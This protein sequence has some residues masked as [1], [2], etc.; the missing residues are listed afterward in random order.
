MPAKLRITAGSAKPYELEIGDT[1]TIG[2]SKDNVVCL[3]ASPNASR[4]HAFIRSV[5]GH[6]YQLIDLGSRN[7]TYLNDS[8]VVAPVT[9]ESGASIRIAD[10]VIV[11]EQAPQAAPVAPPE[12]PSTPKAP[13]GACRET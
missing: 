12:L 8:R 7:G 13:A 2:R 4:Q 1:T 9:L 3:S 6:H 10:N 11:F 5:D